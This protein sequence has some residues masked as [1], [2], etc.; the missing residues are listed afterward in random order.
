MPRHKRARRGEDKPTI[1]GVQMPGWLASILLDSPDTGEPVILPVEPAKRKPKPLGLILTSRQRQTLIHP[2][3]L[4]R[5]IKDRLKK[6][7]EGTQ[8]VEFTQKELEEMQQ[9]VNEATLVCTD[10]WGQEG[11]SD[12]GEEDPGRSPGPRLLCLQSEDANEE[13]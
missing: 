6:S 1:E 7:P 11:T 3:R 9:E 13:R 10:S 2:T 8:F 4:K 12:R 5:K